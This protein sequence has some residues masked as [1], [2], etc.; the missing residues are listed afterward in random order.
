[1]VEEEE[2][3]EAE[4]RN[5]VKRT[6]RVSLA[7]VSLHSP[8]ALLAGDVAAPVVLAVTTLHQLL[9]VGVVA[10]AT[11]HQVTAVAATGRFVALSENGRGG[12]KEREKEREER[13][14]K[15]KGEQGRGGGETE[16][17]TERKKEMG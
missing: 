12:E 3:G 16:R 5:E 9:R 11:A 6:R 4:R 2:E 8:L 7:D 10:T 15:E 1:M 17:Q 13:R 14:K